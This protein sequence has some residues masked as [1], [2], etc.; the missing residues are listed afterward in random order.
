MALAFPSGQSGKSKNLHQPV[1]L[2]LTTL[3]LRGRIK[4]EQTAELNK[5]F[6]R[7]LT[8][9]G[10]LRHL[11]R[12]LLDARRERSREAAQGRD[13]QFTPYQTAIKKAALLTPAAPTALDPLRT[14]EIDPVN[15]REAREYGRWPQAVLAPQRSFF[16]CRAERDFR[17]H[18]VRTRAASAKPV[19]A[20]R[21]SENDLERSA[22]IEAW[23]A[24]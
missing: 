9:G 24:H 1:A 12:V 19:R 16:R 10:N 2:P 20:R 17:H 22:Q 11:S 5:P 8:R 21:V 23:I 18:G 15:G 13:D 3:Q 14:F 7:A 6:W 4:N